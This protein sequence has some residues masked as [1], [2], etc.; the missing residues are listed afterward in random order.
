MI[1]YDAPV[2]D[3]KFLLFDVMNGAQTYGNLADLEEFTPD[4]A[5]TVLTEM[6]KFAAGV[7]LPANRPGDEQGC[8][9]DAETRSVRAPA[10][11]RSRARARAATFAMPACLCVGLHAFSSGRRVPPCVVGA[12]VR[13]SGLSNQLV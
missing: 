7:F 6:G 8:Q 2:E 9:Y 5:E 4:L 10:G 1:E 3:L 13:G 12:R 11:V